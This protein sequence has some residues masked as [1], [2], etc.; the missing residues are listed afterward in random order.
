MSLGAE[1]GW[2]LRPSSRSSGEESV[3]SRKTGSLPAVVQASGSCWNR[4]PFAQH[5]TVVFFDVQ[6]LQAL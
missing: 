6:L 3:M 4:G 1:A 5:D 2:I